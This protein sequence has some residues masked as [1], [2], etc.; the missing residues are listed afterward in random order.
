MQLTQ[1]AHHKLAKIIQP[2]DLVVDA[3]I[4]NGHD[5]CF[6]AN[7]VGST[8]LVIGFDI[9]TQAIEK[10]TLKLKEQTLESRVQL[11]QISHACL[12][13]ILQPWI[14]QRR[15]SAI[16]FN[17]GYLPRGNKNITTQVASTLQALKTGFDLLSKKGCISLLIYTGHPG[18]Q[19]EAN[20]V[21]AWSKTIPSDLA[22]IEHSFSSNN[23]TSFPPELLFIRRKK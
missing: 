14:G 13:S 21:K 20:A 2:G 23:K 17:L 10:T 15:C 3:T 19:A 6:L 1:I 18:G 11:H 5:T 4:G 16:V 12:Q 9:Q 22:T 8:G 7:K